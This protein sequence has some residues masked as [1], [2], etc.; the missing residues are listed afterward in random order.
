MGSTSTPPG[1]PRLRTLSL[2]IEGPERFTKD[3]LEVLG[4]ECPSSTIGALRV[5]MPLDANSVHNIKILDAY[6]SRVNSLKYIRI[7]LNDNVDLSC[8]A[9]K[10]ILDEI[11]EMWSNLV[12][13]C[14]FCWYFFSC[15]SYRKDLEMK[16]RHFESV[17][18]TLGGERFT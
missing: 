8:D 15:I 11:I 6:G 2:E 4:S 12:A 5:D 9:T 1:P 10:G 13:P 17:D 18:N 7:V 16:A 14:Q 3:R